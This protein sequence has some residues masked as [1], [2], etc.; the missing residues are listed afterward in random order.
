MSRSLVLWLTLAVVCLSDVGAQQADT[1]DT[2]LP[3][4]ILES[5]E[6]LIAQNSGAEEFNT[7][8]EYL[9]RLHQHPLNLNSVTVRQ[10]EE[11]TT[12]G[13]LTLQ[14]VSSIL[15]YRTKYGSFKDVNEL[16]ALP[17]FSPEQVS[18]LRHFFTA[19]E[20]PK[21]KI[22]EL[23]RNIP[24][25]THNIIFRMQRYLELAEGFKLPDTSSQRFLGDPWRIYLRYQ[26]WLRRQLGWG[27]TAEK[28]PGEQLFSGYIKPDPLYKIWR[29]FDFFSA[30]FL[31]SPG[32]IV[33]NLILGDYEIRFGQGLV[34]WTGFGFGK[35]PYV[36]SFRRAGEVLRPYTSVNEVR[37]LRGAALHLQKGAVGT[38]LFAS[39]K[40]MDASFQQAVDTLGDTPTVVTYLS[41]YGYH[42][43]LEELQ[44]AKNIRQQVVGTRLFLENNWLKAGLTAIYT[45]LNK[46]LGV[47]TEHPYNKFYLRGNQLTNLG[48]DYELNWRSFYLF[49]EV[50][51]SIPGSWATTHGLLASL[52]RQ[53]NVGVLYRYLSPDYHSLLHNPVTEYYRGENE[54]GIY[55]ALHTYPLPR[56]ELSAYYDI[57][58]HPWLR[59]ERDAPTRGYDYVVRLQYEERRKLQAYILYKNELRQEN[60]RYS[61]EPLPP[62]RWV[63][64]SYLRLHLRR[65]F[66]RN[67]RYTARLQLSFYDNSVNPKETGYM[68]YQEIKYHSNTLRTSFY[69]RLA[70]F[71]I[72]SWYTRIYVY[73]SDVLYYFSVPAYYGHGLRYYLMA[74][75][76][77]NPNLTLWIRLSRTLYLDRDFVGSDLNRT[78]GPART[79]LKLQA[80]LR[81]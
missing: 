79:E 41:D 32:G 72:P 52:A 76:Y 21:S 75:I 10:L 36:L 49:G 47:Y 1:Q 4:H 67:L 25:G 54:E 46:P 78:E 18:V 19:E 39:S 45:T 15:E 62:L 8:L 30:Y 20:E 24:Q 9:Q 31:V 55:L 66:T 81:L 27:F 50:G 71:Q 73:E 61:P 60:E 23:V 37:F 6:E 53:V 42:R 35:S 26:Y 56:W 11:L 68:F 70:Y 14:Q 2:E 38:I 16:V 40:H 74:S 28:D 59:W 57:Y 33:K 65:D 58:Q 13:I 69:A 44:S 48:T 63:R 22:K 17:G 5:L 80:R 29:G 7:A 77:V 3:E 43:N 64:Y 34:A 12:L 51:Y